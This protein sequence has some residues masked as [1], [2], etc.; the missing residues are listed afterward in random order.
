[1][2]SLFDAAS[3]QEVPFGILQYVQC[4]LYGLTNVLPFIFVYSE[5]VVLVVPCDGFLYVMAIFFIVATLI[6]GYFSNS[7]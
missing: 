2:S 1:M 3:D 6:T 7:S 5:I 4:I